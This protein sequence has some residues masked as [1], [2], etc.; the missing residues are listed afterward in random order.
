MAALHPR[1]VGQRVVVRS[2]VAGEV[3]PT[4]GPAFTDVLGILEKWADGVLTIRTADGAGVEIPQALVVSGKPVPPRPSRF[5]RLSTDE[6]ALRCTDFFKPT[7]VLEIGDWLARYS[8]NPL[9]MR[10]N[11]FLPIGDPGVPIDDALQAIRSFYSAHERPS[12]AQAIV[13]SAA[14]SA[15]E[16]R[17]WE[18][19]RPDEA[20]ADVLLAGISAL[21]RTLREVDIDAVDHH[22]VLTYDWLIDNPRAQQNFDAV[23]ASL[24]LGQ[25]TFGSISVDGTIVAT[26]R[27]NLS[28]DWALFSDLKVRSD[29][30]RRGFARALMAAMTPWAAERG[31]SVMALQVLSDN[32]PA[33][34]LYDELGFEH[35]HA[36]RYLIPAASERPERPTDVAAG[37]IVAR[38][39]TR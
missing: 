30:R 14:Q 33:R 5:R 3:G 10:P 35:H 6:V 26:A 37:R 19:L 4:G 21:A 2:L 36:Y 8:D 12:V 39:T 1:L 15:L 24:D 7:D 9:N 17:G 18:R 38:G 20:D 31:A 23:A 34:A 11:S 25:V 29:H 13:G 16:E 28:G 32:E 27:T 22:G